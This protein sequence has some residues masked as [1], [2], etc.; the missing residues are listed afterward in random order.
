[1]LESTKLYKGYQIAI[2]SK[3]KKELDIKENEIVEWRSD[4]T[5]RTI[6]L[7][8]RKK[9]SVMDL[10]GIIEMDEETNAVELKHN[11]QRGKL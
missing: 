9:E 7:S 3:I 2:P 10:A 1:M 8:F 11:V 5:T 4:K 6:T